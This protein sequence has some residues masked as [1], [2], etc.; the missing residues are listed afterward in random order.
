MDKAKVD[1]TINKICTWI[2]AE[3]STTRCINDISLV[4]G[5]IS[6]L[7]E[8]IKARAEADKSSPC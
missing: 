7:A 8:L 3:L 5:M 2:D 4:T 6:A 1:E